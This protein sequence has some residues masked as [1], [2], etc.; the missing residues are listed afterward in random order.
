MSQFYMPVKVVSGRGCVLAQSELISGFGQK[1]MIVSGRNSAKINGSEAEV[2]QALEKEKIEVVVYNRIESNPTIESCYEAAQYAKDEQVDFIIAIGGGS[3]M[4]AA[5]AIA[6]L[7][8]QDIPREKLFS[9]GYAKKRLPMVF[10]P[11]TAGTG[12][13]VTQYSILTNHEAKTKS[14]LA[15]EII[16]PDLAFLDGRYTDSVSLMTTIN[17]AVDALSH[18][19]EGMLCT[20]ANELSDLFAKESIATIARCIPSL[21]QAKAGDGTIDLQVRE[22]L[23]LASMMAGVVIAQTGTTVVHGMG[24]SLTYFKEIDH[25]RANG[26]LLGHYLELIEEKSPELSQKVVK[27]LGLQKAEQVTEILHELLGEGECIQEEEV[28][29]YAKSAFQSKNM[30]NTQVKPSEEEISEL[31]R[32]GLRCTEGLVS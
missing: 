2:L 12:S 9:G 26:L 30:N 31:F 13:E 15:T 8:V 29:H 11:T 3:P 6:L 18:S 23:L 17:T 28:R 14:G 4:D 25:G 19:I 16:F 7:A 22:D 20:R 5:K 1:A 32:K 21:I 10:I 24:Y 27:S